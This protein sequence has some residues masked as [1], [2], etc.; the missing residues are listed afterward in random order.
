MERNRI[1]TFAL[2][3]IALLLALLIYQY[4]YEKVHGQMAS[5]RDL[6]LSKAK[7]LEKY[8]TVLSEKPVWEGKLA[9]LKEKRKADESKL[10]EA[11][12]LSLAAATLVDTAKGI[13]TG[14]GGSL[15]SERVEK[16]EDLG[17]F[18]VVNVS[19][20]ATLPDIRALSDVIYGI[21]TRTPYIVIRELDVR[22]RD[23][24]QPRDLMVRM[25]VASLTGAH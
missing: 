4:G 2:P 19:M 12:T 9:A 16:P 25:R 11:Q 1:V 22:V 6:Q 10:I 18:R 8:M 23:L 21:E 3:L 17:R 15:S 14:K 7:T 5:V 13:I 20:D 24:R